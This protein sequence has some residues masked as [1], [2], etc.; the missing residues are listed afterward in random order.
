MTQIGGATP[1][2]ALAY[3]LS[4]YNSGIALLKQDSLGNFKRLNT[5]ETTGKDGSIT[6]Q[7][8]NCQ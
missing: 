8:N 4:K 5:K 1:E 3:I 2:I 7:P 6:Y